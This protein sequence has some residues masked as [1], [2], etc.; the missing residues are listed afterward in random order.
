MWSPVGPLKVSPALVCMILRAAR[1]E[2][3]PT[4]D[5]RSHTV[6]A[7]LYLPDDL[8]GVIPGMAARAHFVIGGGRI[9]DFCGI[10]LMHTSTSQSARKSCI[11]RTDPA[12]TAPPFRWFDSMV[13]AGNDS[14][15]VLFM[16]SL[17]MR[18]SNLYVSFPW[19]AVRDHA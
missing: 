12:G 18:S 5:A 17:S 10:D 1:V 14:H 3:L 19:S 2:V 13:E 7:R 16:F 8:P 11:Q 4:A 9:A 6:T 15:I